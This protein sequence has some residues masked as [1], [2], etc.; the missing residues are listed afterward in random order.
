VKKAARNGEEAPQ[1]SLF[2]LGLATLLT[3]QG[4]ACSEAGPMPEATGATCPKDS[5][6]TYEDD[7]VPFLTKY[8]TTCHSSTLPGSARSGAPSDHNF[9]T[10]Y[11]VVTNA[12][13]ID[14]YAGA[15][16]DS[17]NS[18]MPPAG[19]PSPSVNERQRLSEWLACRMGGSLE[20]SDDEAR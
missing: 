20:S 13:H 7:V 18:I 17:I 9:D 14:E 1:R 4:L 19:H 5:D 12:R 16:P 15:G 11:D 2:W 6:S 10:L 3:A 8:C